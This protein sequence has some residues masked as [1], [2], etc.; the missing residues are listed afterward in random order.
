M[1]TALSPSTSLEESIH[2]STLCYSLE[3]KEAL[4]LMLR[5]QQ[6]FEPRNLREACEALAQLIQHESCVKLMEDYHGHVQVL[7]MMENLTYHADIQQT[8][9]DALANMMAASEKLRD[10]IQKRNMHSEVLEIVGKHQKDAGVQEA[11][12]RT[13][14]YLAMSSDIC[15]ALLEEDVLEVILTSMNL[16]RENDKLQITSCQA[17]RQILSE[18]DPVR[19]VQF[20]DEDHHHSVMDTI[21]E[22]KENANVLTEAFL[23]LALLAHPEESYDVLLQEVH[24]CLIR[25]M[26]AFPEHADLQEAACTLLESVAKTFE[27]QQLLEVNGASRLVLQALHKFPSNGTLQTTCLRTLNCLAEV[28]FKSME[29][30]IREDCMQ[31]WLDDVITGITSNLDHPRCQEAGCLAVTTLLN[32]RPDLIQTVEDEMDGPVNATKITEESNGYDNAVL[33]SLRVYGRTDLLVFIE[34]CHALSV[35]GKYSTLLRESL[36]AKGAYMDVQTGMRVHNNEPEAQAAAC[37]AVMGLC[38]YSQSDKLAVARCG[39]HDDIFAALFLYSDNLKVLEAGIGAVACLADV[40]FVRHQCMVIG[41]H[42]LILQTMVGNPD[43]CLIQELSLEAL[44]ALSTAEGMTEILCEADALTYTVETMAY[45]SHNEG[46]QQ[47][48]SILLQSLVAEQKVIDDM[49]LASQIAKA[50]V[51]AMKKFHHD[52]DVLVETC[53]AIQLLA[54]HS[55][56]VGVVLVENNVHAELFFIFETYSD[57]EVL[58]ELACGCLYVLCLKWD[59]RSTILLWAS[60]Q[61]MK[62]GVEILVELGADINQGEG[63]E[64]PLCQACK[65]EDVELVQILLRKQGSSDVQMALHIS[66]E[67]KNDTIVGLLLEHMGYDKEGGVVSWNGFNLS[68]IEP[69]WLYPTFLGEKA[70]PRTERARNSTLLALRI[71]QARINRARRLTA[72]QTFLNF[73]GPG[74]FLMPVLRKS[75]LTESMRVDG[76][77]NVLFRTNSFNGA[78]TRDAFDVNELSPV[79]RVTRREAKRRSS[80]VSEG[81]TPFRLVRQMSVDHG[82]EDLPQRRQSSVTDEVSSAERRRSSSP[83]RRLSRSP[84]RP[85]G[86]SS[87]NRRS[88]S[89]LSMHRESISSANLPINPDDP[90]CLASLRKEL[91]STES[92]SIDDTSISGD[93]A[94]VFNEPLTQKDYEAL[95]AAADSESMQVGST[96]AGLSAAANQVRLAVH[97]ANSTSFAISDL[98]SS[99]HDSTDPEVGSSSEL[100]RGMPD[101]VIECSPSVDE[102]SPSRRNVVSSSPHIPHMRYR[103]HIRLLDLSNNYLVDIKSLSKAEGRLLSK[104]VRIEKLD[105]SN[106][107]LVSFQSRL[108]Q[109]MPELQHLD[110]KHNFL[111]KAPFK[112]F[113]NSK[114]TVLDLSYNQ[115]SEIKNIPDDTSYLLTELNLSHNAIEEFPTWLSAYAP[116]LAKLYMAGNKLKELPNQVLG[117]KRLNLLDLSHN[118]LPSIPASF[119]KECPALESLN[120]SHNELMNLPDGMNDGLIHLASVKLS[121]NG[122]A[123]PEPLYIPKLLL[124]LPWL[125]SLDL[126]NNGLTGLPPPTQWNS[127]GLKEVLVSHNK[128]RKLQ[129]SGNI[130]P[131]QKLE[132][133]SVSYNKLTQIPRELGQ[134]TALT[135]L[136]ISNNKGITTIP[137]EIGKLGRLWEFPLEGLKLD[138]DPAIL[139]GRTKDIVGFLNQKLKKAVPYYRMKLMFVG[140]GG[141]GKSTLLARLKRQKMSKRLSNVATAG[142]KV[143][144]WKIPVRVGRKAVDFCLSTW[145]FAG[146]EEFYSTHPCFLTGRSLFIVVFDISRGPDEVQTLRPWM[147]TIQA[148]APNCPVIVVGTH[149]DKVPKDCA[150][151][152]VE[153]MWIRVR[154]LCNSPGFPEVKGYMDLCCTSENDGIEKLRKLI[155]EAIESSKIKGQPILGQMIPYSYLRLEEIL[156]EEARQLHST[157]QVPVVL[158]SRMLQLVREH[159]LQLEEDELAQAVRFLHETG[160]LLHYDDPANQLRDMYFVEPEWLCKIM[161]QVVTV[162]EIN[163][164]ISPKGELRENDLQVLYSRTELP[165]CLIPQYRKL[166]E[167]FEVALP[168]NDTQLLIPCKMPVQRPTIHLPRGEREGLLHRHYDMP[169]IPIGL[170]SRLIIRLHLFSKDMLGV[171]PMVKNA[172][173]SEPAIEYWREGIYVK[174]AE[175]AFFLVEP[176]CKGSDVLTIT[177]P[178]TKNGYRLLAMVCDHLDDLIEEW[179]PG[180]IEVDPMMGR[181]LVRRLI[182][183]VQC[184]V[185]PA[186]RFILDDL[187]MHSESSTEIICP[188]HRNQPVPLHKLAPDVMLADLDER[189]IIDHS[190]FEFFPSPE[191]VLGD[192]SYGS[193]YKAKYKDKPVAV[194]VFSKGSDVHPHRLLRQEVTV[195][196]HLQHPS[197]VSLEGVSFSPSRILVL[198]LAPHGSL[199]SLLNE[200]QQRLNNRQLQ[201]K[202]AIQI[203]EGLSFLHKNKI[204][205]RDLK[206]DNILIFSLA[207]NS[208]YNAKIADYGIS[209]FATPYGLRAPEGTPGYRAPEVIRGIT[210]YNTEVDIY[211]LG[212]LLYEM[213]SGGKKPFAELEFRAELDEAVMRGRQLPPITQHAGVAPWPDLQELIR[214]CM[215]HVPQHR[216]TAEQV[217]KWLS[218][219]DLISLKKTYPLVNDINVESSTVRTYTHSKEEFCEVWFAGGEKT[220]TMLSWVN[221]FC[222][223]PN[224][225]IQGMVFSK[226][227]ALSIV[228]IGQAFIL[229][230]TQSGHICVCDVSAKPYGLF[231]CMPALEDAILSLVFLQ[232]EEKQQ[233]SK[234]DGGMVL[235]G[236]ANGKLAIYSYDTLRTGTDCWPERV[237]EL[238]TLWEPLK[239]MCLSHKRLY[240]ASGGQLIAVDTDDLLDDFETSTESA[241]LGCLGLGEKK[242]K[243]IK[244]LAVGK[245]IWLCRRNSTVVEIWDTNLK[246]LKT[247]MDIYPKITEVEPGCS[248]FNCCIK[249]LLLAGP[250][251]WL[252]T[253]G[254]HLIMIDTNTHQA[255]AVMR[256]YN[257]DVRTIVAVSAPAHGKESGSGNVIVT[258]GMGFVRR[259]GFDEHTDEHYSHVMIWDADIKAQVRHMQISDSARRRTTNSGS[260]SGSSGW[261][262]GSV[263]IVDRVLWKALQSARGNPEIL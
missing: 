10:L 35:V 148:L 181:P 248:V 178:Q 21:N 110:L 249:S 169:Y 202:I 240:M 62:R 23:L 60:K 84:I 210:T 135:S 47:K 171:G 195:L 157:R 245:S 67:K 190:K 93:D 42:E 214:H 163:P 201:H 72:V 223:D 53:V 218:S 113:S 82:D 48:G 213:V 109:A 37:H 77:G 231:H 185:A 237:V 252:G 177:V 263:W 97:I 108:A 144:E 43:N 138:L 262:K 128:I 230:G 24:K 115:I 221:P 134:L 66:L 68:K 17:L 85:R 49:S 51:A 114:L 139:R 13:I 159:K 90:R 183:C 166:L 180:L 200:Q 11:A 125:R 9:F 173:E 242:P 100:A 50:L 155:T 44:A 149:M 74:S 247:T 211:S 106:N 220:T 112:V 174:W 31:T 239:C 251:I 147:L 101:V 98:E 222:A 156:Q 75:V 256:R 196:R 259:P 129:L 161:A 207:L 88:T 243:M 132:R 2:D 204:V 187:M 164:F 116:A 92:L 165:E 260:V 215:E 70:P 65:R 78:E 20:V 151:D 61:N 254:G 253:A 198:E 63:E 140:Y 182:P 94:S 117:L 225:S 197:L 26:K 179:F 41:I 45:Y 18:A 167:K 150:K 102:G 119:L 124:Q 238:G 30:G 46:I 137:D 168:I 16:F 191:Y 76:A 8:G 258:S 152:F 170:W 96:S 154:S 25:A 12:I 261:K 22:H 3:D 203:A 257:E 64:T 40:A 250:N 95:L 79:H 121:H 14:K 229:A 176:L 99:D 227:R 236:L 107:K 143:N 5:L 206:P 186:H 38:S 244:C 199:A 33:A 217:R 241:E 28:M 172:S 141:R 233:K 158:H 232:N 111:K 87:P 175:D 235:A 4:D 224:A 246:K 83:N 55:R 228:A 136:D 19:Q 146:Q 160:I 39:I 7:D 126:C 58:V 209:K 205:Y 184:T 216:P 255:V 27:S 142:V 162:R 208:A 59:F 56:E 71:R 34:A 192:G 212:I 69:A 36:M 105:L 118:S 91:S 104:F 127:Q 81:V 73:P 15:K 86:S 52:P 57:N 122:L 120:L 131:W 103:Q 234:P 133:L 189:L 226:G 1:A 219:P 145:D 130:R 6:D 193:V 80:S 29:A 89:F 123:Q 32:K 188:N 54:E 153:D 194:K